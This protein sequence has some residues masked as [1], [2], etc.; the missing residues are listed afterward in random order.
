MIFLSNFVKHSKYKWHSI[1][2]L[3]NYRY[4]LAIEENPVLIPVLSDQEMNVETQQDEYIISIRVR[5]TFS[6]FHSAIYKSYKFSPVIR[7]NH[8]NGFHI[9]EIYN[10]FR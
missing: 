4:Y 10:L 1:I 5:K 9:K 8:V 7:K 3:K 6:I 2:I